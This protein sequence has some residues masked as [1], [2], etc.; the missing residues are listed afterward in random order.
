MYS[1]KK[2][3]TIFSSFVLF[4]L[5]LF[6]FPNKWILTVFSKN[7]LLIDEILVEI[8]NAV[9]L[10][11]FKKQNQK[12]VLLLPHCLRSSDCHARCDPFYGYA[13]THCGRC[14]ISEIIKEAKKRDFKVFIIPGGSFIKKIFKENPPT[15]WIAVACPVELS[16]VMQKISIPS[17]GVYLLN[18]GCFETKVNISDVISKMELSGSLLESPSENNNAADSINLQTLP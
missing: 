17:Q 18:S 15:S 10:D 11:K 12:K 8:Q 13:C 16:E 9:Y 3:K 1:L 2:K 5:Y 7:D 14:D 6:Y 4:M